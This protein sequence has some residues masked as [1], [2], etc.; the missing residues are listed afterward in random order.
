M[1][2]HDGGK[3]GGKEGGGGREEE[4]GRKEASPQ[5]P[6]PEGQMLWGEQWSQSPQEH[7]RGLNQ[8]SRVLGSRSGV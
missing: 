8:G 4:G 5:G 1:S 3:E 7:V 6:T 2:S